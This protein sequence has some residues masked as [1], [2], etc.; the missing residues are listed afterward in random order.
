[1]LRVVLFDVERMAMVPD[2]SSSNNAVSRIR[3]DDEMI[4]RREVQR[5]MGNVSISSVY[6]DPDLMRLKVN[7]MA[8]DNRSRAVRWIAREIHELRARRVARSEERG[9]NVE[10]QIE[11]RHE[12]RRTRQRATAA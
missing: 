1:M 6:A 12:R 10:A 3:P 2:N 7:L 4:D 8:K 5:V 11:K 9:A